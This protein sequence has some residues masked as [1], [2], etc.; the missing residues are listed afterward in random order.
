MVATA[1]DENDGVTT[2]ERPR[3]YFPE[4]DGVRFIAFAC[5]FVR[6][7]TP[8]TSDWWQ[9]LHLG[10]SVSRVAA[11]VSQ[12]G[13]FGVY[14]FFTL[15]AYLIT[16]LL[17]RERDDLGAIRIRAFYIRRALR[18]WPL[19]FTYLALAAVFAIVTGESVRWHEAAYYAVFVANWSAIYG[20]GWVTVV[21]HLW[22]ISVEEQF[23]LL[24]PPLL[25]RL[26]D[27][28]IAWAALAMIT[29]MVIGVLVGPTG[30]TYALTSSFSCFSA[31]GVGILLALAARRTALRTPVPRWLLFAFGYACWYAAAAL[32]LGTSSM[33]SLA[34]LALVDVGCAA[35]LVSVLGSR[36]F[37]APLLYLGKISYGLYVFHIFV[38]GTAAL[39]LNKHAM[40]A[41]MYPVLVI[42]ELIATVALAALSY[43][44]LEAPFLRLKRH[45]E[46][47]RSRP[48]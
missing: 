5:V 20:A 3:L 2:A 4:L 17:L 1:C 33:R 12:S 13:A 15:S 40:T 26:G 22:S 39:V 6:H 24:W 23:Y 11:T 46:F 10:S 16:Q 45:F 29:S 47:V 21:L 36:G 43:R 35:M 28:G 32:G 27:R 38:L 8:N 7:A 41:V 9:K 42:G 31:M 34:A 18:I 14:L 30:W 44:Y 25:R 19:Y 37:A 48:V